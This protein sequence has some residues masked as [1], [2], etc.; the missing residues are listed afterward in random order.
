MKE[1]NRKINVGGVALFNGILFTSKYRQ[2]SIQR[3]NEKL[4][5]KVI[6]LT[7]DKRIINYIFVA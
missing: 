3:N 4:E 2:V 5:A 6:P 7:E 1:N